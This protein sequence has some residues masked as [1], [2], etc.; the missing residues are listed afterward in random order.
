MEFRME[1]WD[2]ADAWMGGMD[3]D[4]TVVRPLGMPSAGCLGTGL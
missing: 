3:A 4:S 2:A 1:R